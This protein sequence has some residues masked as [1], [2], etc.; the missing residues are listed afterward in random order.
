MEKKDKTWDTY[1][2]RNYSCIERY[3]RLLVPYPTRTAIL[4][5][6]LNRISQERMISQKGWTTYIENLP[7]VEVIYSVAHTPSLFKRE[8]CSTNPSFRRDGCKELI[9]YRRPI[10]SFLLNF[11][12]YH[13]LL[14]SKTMSIST[15]LQPLCGTVPEKFWNWYL[16]AKIIS[17][18][19]KRWGSMNC[20][21]KKQNI[22]PWSF[23]KS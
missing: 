13:I 3:W 20:L 23:I 10:H 2:T 1:P 4:S 15:C 18:K 16:F 14:Y 19:G 11:Q 17:V 21:I 9:P 12:L 7:K 22:S 6:R 5:S 8:H